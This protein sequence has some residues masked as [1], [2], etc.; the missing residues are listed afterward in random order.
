MRVI[1]QNDGSLW[2]EEPEKTSGFDMG[3]RSMFIKTN[4]KGDLNQIYFS[5][6]AHAGKWALTLSVAGKPLA[7]QSAQALGHLWQLHHQSDAVVI[8]ATVFLEDKKPCVF[9]RLEIQALKEKDIDLE[10]MLVIDITAPPSPKGMFKDLVAKTLPRLPKYSWYWG[11]GMGRWLQTPAPD[12]LLQT[13]KSS[14]GAC[15]KVSWNL[16]ANHPFSSCQ[17]QHKT[18]VLRF[19]IHIPA[20]KN[21]CLDF[22]LA[23][24]D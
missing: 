13:G 11:W 4:G 16:A 1:P 12:K 19:D 6:G 20:G 15:G 3:N 23:D 22:V 8:D 2:I 18:A 7:F 14:L 24:K 10:I 17:I 5:K 21:K 9:E